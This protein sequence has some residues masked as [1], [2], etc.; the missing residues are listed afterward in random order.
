L[1]EYGF[2]KIVGFDPSLKLLQYAKSRLGKEFDP[3]V[4]V[5]E[6]LPFRKGAFGA[7]L[8]CFS[9]RDVRNPIRSLQEFERVGN[10]DSALAI[11]D[12]GRPDETVR[13]E[14]VWLYV[15]AIMPVLAKTLVRNRLAGNPFKM[16]IPTFERLTTNR[17]LERLL[18]E[19]F[20]PATLQEFLFGG[21][22]ILLAYHKNA[23]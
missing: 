8:T 1:I 7:M 6:Y 4:G 10:H 18:R 2:T 11:V 3:V 15:R 21:L 23:C 20:G 12:V 13:R 16:I 14:L 9:L 17:A 22:V 19:N 5:A